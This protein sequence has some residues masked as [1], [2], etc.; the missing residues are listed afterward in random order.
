MKKI[1]NFLAGSVLLVLVLSS[2]DGNS[3][4]AKL[5]DYELAE[6]HGRCLDKKPTAP[7]AKIIC[8]NYT[9]ECNRRKKELGSYVCRTY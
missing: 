1:I 2:C 5:S 6:Q 9:K 7:G 3:K 4:F 8:E